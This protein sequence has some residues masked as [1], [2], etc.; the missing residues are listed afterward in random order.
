M[1]LATLERC[2]SEAAV[3][4][5]TLLKAVRA[6]DVDV[7]MAVEEEAVLLVGHSAVSADHGVEALLDS[8]DATDLTAVDLTA[9]LIMDLITVLTTIITDHVVAAMALTALHLVKADHILVRRAST[10]ESSSTILDPAL[11][12]TSQGQLRT[13]G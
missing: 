2:H 6:K 11:G 12:S 7:V 4:S 8:G 9:D 13:L 10:S 1:L 3:A 5:H